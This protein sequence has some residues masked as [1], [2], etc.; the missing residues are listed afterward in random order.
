ME[1]ETMNQF[2]EVISSMRPITEEVKVY[3]VYKKGKNIE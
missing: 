3:G 2:E 1:F